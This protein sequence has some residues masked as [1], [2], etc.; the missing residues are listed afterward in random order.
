MRNILIAILFAVASGQAMA[1][2]VI[3]DEVPASVEVRDIVLDIGLGPSIGPKWPS[4]KRY[5]PGVAPFFDLQFLRLPL[6]GEV[7]TGESRAFSI[8]PS[9]A[10]I[11]ERDDSDAAYLRGIP[12]RDL[13]VE[14]GVG[15]SFE[16]AWV[17]AVGALRYGV[18]GHNGFVGEFGADLA[19]KNVPN[20]ELYV[21]PRVGFADDSYMDTYFSVPLT[22]RVLAPF[23]ADAGITTVGVNLEAKYAITEKVRL[24]GEARWHHFVGDAL[25]S[26]I[27]E[28]G[29]DHEFFAKIGL[30]YRFGVDLF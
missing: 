12:D 29:N 14:A 22:A 25:D 24:H 11:G 9:I 30:T 17:R 6:F 21:G 16:T 13:S 19:V 8:Y 1:A 4:S 3:V 7:V 27:T 18:V 23:D 10:V 2:D 28:R 26:P 15:A 5:R 20:L